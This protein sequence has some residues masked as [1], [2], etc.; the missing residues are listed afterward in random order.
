[1]KSTKRIVAMSLCIL[2]SAG[3]STAYADNCNGRFNNV[4]HAL[5]TVEVAKGHTLTSFI[6]HSITTS[7]N[8]INNA[9]GECSGYALTTPDGKTRMSGICA[10]KTAEGDSFSDTWTLEP[11]ADRGTWKMVG[12]TGGFAGKV[13]S[14]WWQMTLQDGK[15]ASGK[16]GGNC[17]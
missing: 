3:V 10:R 12:A 4:T 9:A 5:S 14:G 13:M 2:A 8:S 11:G 16:W 1:M 7:D 15:M 6:F 17:N